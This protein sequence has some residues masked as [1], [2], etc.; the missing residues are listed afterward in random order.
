MLSGFV[1]R[2]LLRYAS[3]EA[4][5]MRLWLA[6][7]RVA[8]DDTA[9]ELSRSRVQP[10]AGSPRPAGPFRRALAQLFLAAPVPTGST[11]DE[12]TMTHLVKLIHRNTPAILDDAAGVAVL[13]V[14]LF[15]GLTLSGTA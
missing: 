4:G 13:F 10:P 7:L 8:Y 14:L 3:G 1:G 11:N 5:E 9:A 2:Y 12:A 15:V 6:K